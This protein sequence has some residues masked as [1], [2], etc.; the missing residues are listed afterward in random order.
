MMLRPFEQDPQSTMR[1][2]TE[3]YQKKEEENYMRIEQRRIVR[4]FVERELQRILRGEQVEK[5][6]GLITFCGGMGDG[7]LVGSDRE[8]AE[9]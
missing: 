9:G 7:V 3:N 2:L 6:G 8:I 1:E 4:V 5:G